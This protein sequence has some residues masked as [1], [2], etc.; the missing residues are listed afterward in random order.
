[1]QTT[2]R[3]KIADVH[4]GDAFTEVL[5]D[6]FCLRIVMVNVYFIGEPDAVDARGGWTLVDAGLPMSAG[7]IRLAAERLYGTGARPNA[8]I[9]THGHFDHVGALRTLSD[10]WNV[11]IYAH[12]MELPYLTN[13][14]S[15]PPPDPTVGGG[16]MARLSMTYP[17]GPFDFRDRIEALPSDGSVPGLR[18]WGW[19]ATSG[20]SPG[21]VS[22]YRASD[23]ALIAGDAFVTQKQES[24]I[25]VLTKKHG[26]FGP[27][28]Y[29]TPDYQSAAESVRMLAALQPEVGATGHGIPMIGQRLRDGLQRLADHF[30]HLAVPL[31]GRYVERPAVADDRGVISIPPA[32]SDPVPKIILGAVGV[33]ALAAA[34]GAAR[35]RNKDE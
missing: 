33:A 16:V 9:L 7:K 15:Y 24:L 25:G 20:H 31:K 18:E 26:V 35:S 32:P 29:F 13:G 10:E 3:A 19:I 11:P 6:L 27:P 1:M 14:S 21:H 8:I 22:F 28:M 4:S 30:V 34:I 2:T 23:R 5:P 17:R 12:E